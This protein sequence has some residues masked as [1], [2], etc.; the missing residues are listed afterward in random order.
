MPVVVT[1]E[2]RSPTLDV[3]DVVSVVT[4]AAAGVAAVRDADA[5]AIVVDSPDP[6]LID[7]IRETAGGAEIPVVQ[8]TA[9]GEP[10]GP[11]D[12][13]LAPEA[14]ADGAH[15]AIERARA[16]AEYRTAVGALYEACRNR[17]AGRPEASIRELREAADDAYERLDEV[18]PSAFHPSPDDE[19]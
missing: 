18:P 3:L 13:L 11:A 15:D 17:S 14:D 9:E 1:P 6:A 16:V 4:D 5:D 7:A 19:Q 8:I 12:A 10:E 2:S